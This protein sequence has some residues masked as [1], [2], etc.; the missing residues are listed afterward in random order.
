M[1]GGERGAA[2][3]VGLHVQVRAEGA[4]DERHALLDGRVAKIA[5]AEVEQPG[6]RRRRPRAVAADLEHARRRVDADHRHARLRDRDRDPAGA[7]AELDDRP[8][9]ATARPPSAPR[10]RRTRR[11]RR[12]SGSTGRRSRRSGRRGCGTVS[13]TFG[14]RPTVSETRPRK[15]PPNPVIQSLDGRGE[16]PNRGAGG[17]SGRA[18]ARRARRG[19]RPLPR[20]L[21]RAEARAARGA[22]P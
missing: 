2:V 10:R 9:P 3:G 11:P 20:A 13:D 6:R 12:R 17:D 8:P 14:V 15:T 7:D 16:A 18:D 19:A 5:G 22:R 1:C 21:E 4:D